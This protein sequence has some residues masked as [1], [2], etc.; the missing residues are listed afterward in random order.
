MVCTFSGSSKNK[1]KFNM[2]QGNSGGSIHEEDV[3]ESFTGFNEGAT[4]IDERI[5]ELSAFGACTHFCLK[6]TSGFVVMVILLAAIFGA[7]AWVFRDNINAV[8]V[9]G[10]TCINA[11]IINQGSIFLQT[12]ILENITT[13]KS[14]DEL[15]EA[16][17]QMFGNVG[18]TLALL[19]SIEFSMLLGISMEMKQ[20]F[21]SDDN[22]FYED[23]DNATRSSAN[24]D[25]FI[26]EHYTAWVFNAI[27]MGLFGLFS[28]TN[29]M[30]YTSTLNNDH[31]VCWMIDNLR[32]GY[33]MYGLTAMYLSGL[34]LL[35]AAAVYPMCVFGDGEMGL[36]G[37]ACVV[38]VF[39]LVLFCTINFLY[40]SAWSPMGMGGR[41]LPAYMY[42]EDA[43]EM[44]NESVNQK[45]QRVIRSQLKSLIMPSPIS[46]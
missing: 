10:V 30:F 29:T 20:E 9:P 37:I 41:K 42:N 13:G 3:A 7:V 14:K 16:W 15:R 44:P 24:F 6:H 39:I 2:T 33:D 45:K 11:I 1:K 31:F 34:D 23:D 38:N 32:S 26:A 8:T 5:T 46:E 28:V 27:G 36:L 43:P 25:L 12:D 18:L 4:T 40:T 17:N 19:L 22:D 21:Y 35:I